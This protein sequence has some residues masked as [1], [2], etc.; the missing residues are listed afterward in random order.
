MKNLKALFFVL[1]TCITAQTITA[2]PVVI[3]V[4]AGL[5]VQTAT[6]A[7]NSID[8]R[9]IRKSVNKLDIRL[10]TVEGNTVYFEKVKDQAD[11]FRRF[12]LENLADGNYFFCVKQY[13]SDLICKRFNLSNGTV[14]LLNDAS[15]Y[16]AEIVD[17]I[18][19][20]NK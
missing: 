18:D 11:Y 5:F 6:A 15:F 8:L 2:N 1:L 19:V 17:K 4:E 13:G 3:N 16:G 20:L 10:K 7:D 9:I 12:K 14:T